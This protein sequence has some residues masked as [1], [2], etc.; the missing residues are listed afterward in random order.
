[1]K[2]VLI[3]LFAFALLA[4]AV[5]PDADARTE[6]KTTLQLYV[7]YDVILSGT[8]ASFE[9]NGDGTTTYLVDV[10]KYMKN[11]QESNSIS[12]IGQ[13]IPGELTSSRDK[14][15]NVGD[16]AY[17]F[18]TEFEGNYKISPYSFNRQ[19]LDDIETS[20]PLSASAS[21][22]MKERI[23]ITLAEEV[24]QNLSSIIIPSVMSYG[25]Y[26]LLDQLIPAPIK[27]FNAGISED[28][29]VC[30]GDLQQVI[31]SSNGMPACVKQS[32]AAKLISLG[33]AISL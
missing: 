18:L 31:K 1:M 2:Y 24:R 8:I 32:S 7:E 29:L 5:M 13:G 11:P 16:S 6:P 15:F 10:E 4:L 25:E 23:R 30:R 26:S 19:V 14:T 17:L 3:P 22:E 12:V 28:E 21:D 27:A 33:W 9:D 20:N